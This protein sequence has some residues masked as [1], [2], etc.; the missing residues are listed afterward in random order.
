MKLT[1]VI[2]LTLLTATAFGQKKSKSKVPPPVSAFDMKLNAA[3]KLAASEQYEEAGQAFEEMLK[4]DPG[5]GNVY[6]YY[7]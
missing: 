6:Y 7:G 3:L 5:N 4:S 1:T 2:L